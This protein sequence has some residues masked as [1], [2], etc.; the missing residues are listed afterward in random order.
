MNKR[1]QVV[2]RY[3][4]EHWPN[5]QLKDFRRLYEDLGV[6]V[7]YWC[8]FSPEANIISAD[9]AV[10]KVGIESVI[11]Y[12]RFVEK[13]GGRILDGTYVQPWNIDLEDRDRGEA[14][15]TS[16]DC[17]REMAKV[18]ED[19]GVI[20]SMEILNRFEGALVNTM[21]EAVAVLDRVDSPNVKI[22]ADSFHMNIEEDGIDSAIKTG[23]NYISHFH[24][25]EANRKLPGKGSQID[26][27]ELFGTLRELKYD[28]MFI[29]EGFILHGGSIA[30]DVKLW[31]DLSDKATPQELT[32]DLRRSLAFVRNKFE[33]E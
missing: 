21:A 9:P 18:A 5:H 6:D 16:V 2:Q 30:K 3:T 31:R 32:E 4:A 13:M 1:E 25:G 23:G 10:R 12:I 11:H 19:C 27:D 15:D 24:L 8:G 7:A 17:F 28:G 22:T 33:G 26:W 14:L 29:F 20:L